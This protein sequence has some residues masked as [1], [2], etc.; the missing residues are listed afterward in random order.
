MLNYVDTVESSNNSSHL[1]LAALLLVL[2]V[3][4][5]GRQVVQPQPRQ[6]GEQQKKGV[7]GEEPQTLVYHPL[8]E[9]VMNLREV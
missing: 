1:L 8:L 2:L 9:L 5:L 4:V 6:V 7:A 3:A